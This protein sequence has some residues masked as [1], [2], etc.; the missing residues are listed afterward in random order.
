MDARETD[1]P[2]LPPYIT[3]STEQP[4]RPFDSP[5]GIILHEIF[6]KFEQGFSQEFGK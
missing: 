3:R 6:R 4:K 1:P 5:H 2:G